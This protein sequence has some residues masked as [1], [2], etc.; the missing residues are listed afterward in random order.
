MNRNGEKSRVVERRTLVVIAFNLLAFAV[1]V[2]RPILRPVTTPSGVTLATASLLL[3]HTTSP[4]VLVVERAALESELV[5]SEQSTRLGVAARLRVAPS[6]GM[7]MRAAL[8]FAVKLWSI[9][10]R[11]L[12]FLLRKLSRR[13]TSCVPGPHRL[14]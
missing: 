11:T 12:L 3:C 6:L 7:V 10:W 14:R 13:V 1:I 2:A 8:S 4:S 9:R 5:L